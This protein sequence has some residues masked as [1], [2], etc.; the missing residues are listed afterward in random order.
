M[1]IEGLITFVALLLGLFIGKYTKGEFNSGKKYFLV[2]HKILLFCLFIISLYIAWYANLLHFFIAFIAGIIFSFGIKNTYFYLGLLF[3]LSFWGND[4]YFFVVATLIF[5]YGLLSGGLI[6]QKFSK[7]RNIRNKVVF[8]LI[9]FF[10]PFT[11]IYFKSFAMDLN[12][13]IY[14]FISGA[15]FLKFI[16][17]VDL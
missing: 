10:I 17:K 3:V 4:T 2:V 1:I 13:I 5:M 8:S 12:Y 11:L 9:A 15:L 6:M 7:V 14:A 16:K